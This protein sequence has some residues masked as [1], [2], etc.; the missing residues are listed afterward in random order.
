MTAGSYS[1]EQFVESALSKDWPANFDIAYEADM[2]SVLLNQAEADMKTDE[3]LIAAPNFSAKQKKMPEI[4][5]IPG[6]HE[7]H[8]GRGEHQHGGPPG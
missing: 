1:I 8:G 7:K 5:D 2:S 6:R 3:S 4:C